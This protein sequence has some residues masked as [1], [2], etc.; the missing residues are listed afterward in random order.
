MAATEQAFAAQA[1]Y[2]AGSQVVPTPFQFVS[3]A[4]TFLRIVSA[5]SIGGVIIGLQGRR[6]DDSGQL[7]IIDEL[8][9]PNSDRSVKVQDYALGPGALLNLSLS[10][11]VGAPTWG[12]CY[13]RVQILRNVG[14][15]A[16]VLDDILGG[17]ITAR[18]ALGFPG[19]PVRSSREGPGCLVLSGPTLGLGVEIDVTVP[20]GALWELVSVGTTLTTSGA[21]GN[22]RPRLVIT[23][24]GNT[25]FF[26]SIPGADAIGPANA[27]GYYWFQGTPL[28]VTTAGDLLSPLPQKLL[29]YGDSH[30]RTITAGF[31]AADQ[32]GSTPVTA[33]EWLD[34]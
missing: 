5:C 7:Q 30:I 8:H 33:F 23:D 9:T 12:R 34:V 6:L 25:H 1:G 20:E 17:Y 16:I 32:Y 27:A 4:D 22:R 14:A 21:A 13:A 2:L 29:L 18:N 10:V 11:A 31:N 15:T 19:S 24:P 3:D 26:A 28:T